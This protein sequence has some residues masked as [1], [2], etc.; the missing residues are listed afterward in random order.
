MV[1]LTD[2]EIVPQSL[3]E[4]TFL[5]LKCLNYRYAKEFIETGALYF[6]T[7][8]K[9]SYQDGTSR[10]D[11][12]EGVYAS[13]RG[14]NAELDSLLCSLRKC[15]I[16]GVYSGYTYYRSKEILAFRA[17]CFCGLN[18][19]I[20]NLAEQRAQDHRY[21]YRGKISKDYFRE[22]FSNVTPDQ[23]KC[24]DANDRPV[25]LIIKPDDFISLV[26]STLLRMGVKES[27]IFIG[28][29]QYIN[30][31]ARPF[32]IGSEPQE[33]FTKHLKYK[34]QNEVRIVIDTRRKE[35]KDL[36]DKANGVIK[37]GAIGK[38]IATLSE[39]YFEDMIIEERGNTLIYNLATPVVYE[40][41]EVDDNSLVTIMCQALSDELPDSPMCIEA[42]EAEVDKFFKILHERDPG[43]M[44]DKE[45]H[46][47]FY[48]GKRVN[49]AS[50][51]AS[52]MLQ[53]Y[54][55]YMI[56]K[57]YQ[58]A[59]ETIEKVRYFFPMYNFNE[60]FKEYYDKNC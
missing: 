36:F 6:S 9:W 4:K 59:G 2:I 46:T 14:Y 40:I 26:K 60:Y 5:L 3:P 41:N 30:Y 37:F 23:V 38:A 53:H 22:L 24:G 31:R 11:P 52:R 57:D 12:L 25:V 19:D 17:C 56:D 58:S 32:M 29:V 7:I 45:C 16:E 50:K 18:S 51:A 1:T 44:Y 43:A 33:L 55:T 13:Q 8:E 35:V 21:H 47:L 15:P 27:E 48:K 20:M 28:P 54:N 34:E 10:G 49:M 42:I 39:F